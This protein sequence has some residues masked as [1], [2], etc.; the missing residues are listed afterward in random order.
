MSR[1]SK[2]KQLN[3]RLENLFTDLDDGG[4]LNSLSSGVDHQGW[5]WECDKD[6]F[7]TACSPDVQEILGFKPED[8]IGQKIATFSLNDQGK[9][10]IKNA[11][12]RKVYPTQATPTFETADGSPVKIQLD[13][14]MKTTPDGEKNGWQG[15]ARLITIEE[16]IAEPAQPEEKTDVILAESKTQPL[17]PILKSEGD[18]IFA[19]SNAVTGELPEPKLEPE[20]PVTIKTPALAPEPA[21]PQEPAASLIESRSETPKIG[22]E[23]APDSKGLLKIID[24]DP[25]REWSLEELALVEQVASQLSLAMENANL[26]QQTQEALAETDILYQASAELN[27][28]AAY[29][30]IITIIQKH[31]LAHYQPT[32]A[33]INWF[34][35]PW[36]DTQTPEWVDILARQTKLETRQLKPRY[37]FTEL[38]AITKL[39]KKDAPTHIFDLSVDPNVEDDSKK[40]IEELFHAKSVIFIP[41]VIAGDWMGFIDI[42][43]DNPTYFSQA[44][45]RRLNSIGIQATEKI[46]SLYVNEREVIQRSIADQ[47]ANIARVMSNILSESELVDIT[48]ELIFN[49]VVPDQLNLYTLS[50]DKQSLIVSLKT[51]RVP[52]VS[53]DD[54]QV[55]DVLSL[56]DQE[57]LRET[58]ESPQPIYTVEDWHNNFIREH[59]CIPWMIADRVAGVIEIYHTGRSAS[60]TEYDQEYIEGVILQAASSI[61]RASLFEQTKNALSITD[62]Q[63]R[64][65]RILNK[66]SDELTLATTV[67]EIYQIAIDDIIEILEANRA[68]LGMHNPNTNEYQ[69]VAAAGKSQE[70]S[71]GDVVPTTGSLGEVLKSNKII[72]NPDLETED[73]QIRS[74]IVAPISIGNQVAGTINAEIDRENAFGAADETIMQQ[75]SSLLSGVLEN[76]RLFTQIQRRSAQLETSAEV[77]RIASAILDTTELFPRVVELIKDGYDLY[78]VGLFLIDTTGQWTGEPGKWAVLQAGTGEAGR[79]MLMNNHKLEMGGTSM[80]G[81]AV[82]NREARIALDVGEEA[83]FFRNPNLPNTRSEM[84]LPLISRGR[85]LGALSIQSTKEAAF[86]QEDITALQ[87]MADQVANTVE[88]AT[89]FEQTEERAEELAILNEMARAFTQSLEVNTIINNVYEYTSRLMDADNFYLALYDEEKDLIEFKFVIEDGQ[90]T[91][92][93]MPEKD[94]K[95]GIGPA[96]WIIQNKMP[97]LASENVVEEFEKLGFDTSGQTAESWLG[98]PMMRGAK[99]IGVMAIQNFNTPRLYEARHLDLFSA[100]ANQATVAIDNAQ[101]FQETQV[102]AQREQILREITAKVHGSADPDTILRTAVREISTALDRQAYIQISTGELSNGS[103]AQQIKAPQAEPELVETPEPIIEEQPAAEEQE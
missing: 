90:K 98:V 85:V 35:T 95:S 6:G 46:N 14:F 101:R 62:E 31:G 49:R 91:H 55:G 48:A 103:A 89:L 58:L 53:E 78:Y 68:S 100:V 96:E 1:K 69:I 42:Y 93:D 38:D 60:F 36:S 41:I 7:Y 84:A 76:N 37:R 44:E 20:P 25:N 30:E 23:L 18:E 74:T 99:A 83:R 4:Q 2:K 56:V 79:Q 22:T 94:E 11:L 87:T 80:I 13:I 26:F 77:S 21:S 86:S 34:N 45:L 92:Y 39:I 32:I 28:A 3:N 12:R 27:T 66:M 64:R 50:E 5:L 72:I 65:L 51:L 54:Y 59:F 9:K 61:E 10:E 24:S 40:I 102:R 52:D 57:Y 29:D 15:S 88:N 97:L 73:G 81:A 71:E 17:P 19:M 70:A 75:I 67:E 8:I 47:L 82:E 43:F 63:A 16:D 33:S